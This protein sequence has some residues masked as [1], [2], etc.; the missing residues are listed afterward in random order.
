MKFGKWLEQQ[1]KATSEREKENL[2]DFL[3]FSKRE[4]LEEH[5]KIRMEFLKEWKKTT[6]YKYEN[7]NEKQKREV[8][9]AYGM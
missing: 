8:D 5:E 7:L 4:K 3:T 1:M 9:N 6:L 2:R